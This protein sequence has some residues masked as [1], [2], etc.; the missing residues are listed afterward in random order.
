MVKAFITYTGSMI[1]KPK[2]HPWLGWIYHINPLA[3]GFDAMLPNEF[4]GKMIPCVGVNLIPNG[5]GYNNDANYQS[6]AGV[7]GARPGQVA[8]TGDDYLEALSYGHGHVWRNFG[9]IW[10]WC[11][12]FVAATIFT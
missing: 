1:I 12:L 4:H 5:P 3:Y 8:I 6:C 7:G 9:I 11:I 10:A 2:M